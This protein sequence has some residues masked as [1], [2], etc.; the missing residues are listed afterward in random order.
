MNTIIVTTESQLNELITKSVN[1]EFRRVLLEFKA[2]QQSTQP[3]TAS[4]FGDINWFISVHPKHPK[5]ATVYSQLSLKKIPSSLV[6]KPENTKQLMFYKDL[7]LEWIESGMPQ[8][9][10]KSK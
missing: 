2:T 10:N 9:E 1:L 7:V 8:P 4:C 5:K 3:A 6:F